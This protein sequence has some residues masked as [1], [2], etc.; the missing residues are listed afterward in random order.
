MP[1]NAIHLATNLPGNAIHLATNLVTGNL[2]RGDMMA[3]AAASKTRVTA[4][5]AKIELLME[6]H[7]LRRKDVFAEFDAFAVIWA[8]PIDYKME[9]TI[10][11]MTDESCSTSHN[12]MSISTMG[13][14]TSVPRRKR[15]KVCRLPARNEKEIG[16]TEVIRGSPSPKF[17]TS[18]TVDFEF[19]QDKTYIV[20]IYDRDVDFSSDLKEHDFLGGTLFSVAELMA[21]GRRQLKP[22]LEGLRDKNGLKRK[23][24]L[25]IRGVEV[26]S[27]RMVFDL[28]FSVFGQRFE[29]TRQGY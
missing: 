7:N 27:T 26:K 2:W 4:P 29:R 16:R 21:E 5:V 19:H 10:G 8:A 23:S 28:R 13:T 17:M 12:N 11:R 9:P 6:C 3:K 24:F 25:V 22:P 14:T 20:R 18:F 15:P 1:G